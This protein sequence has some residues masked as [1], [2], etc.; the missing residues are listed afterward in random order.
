M[1]L[2]TFVAIMSP[3]AMPSVAIH[4]PATPDPAIRDLAVGA[5]VAATRMG[6]VGMSVVIT[7]TTVTI[8]MTGMAFA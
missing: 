6:I 1:L 5:A 7:M 8:Y 4:V 2:A 3:R